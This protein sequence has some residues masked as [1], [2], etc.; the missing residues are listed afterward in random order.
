MSTWLVFGLSSPQSTYLPIKL[1]IY[2]FNY[3]FI[4]PPAYLPNKLSIP[5]TIYPL[6]N[7][8]FRVSKY[9]SIYL[10]NS[11]SNC[12][13]IH[14]HKRRRAEG[15]QEVESRPGR[16]VQHRPFNTDVILLS[17]AGQSSTRGCLTKPKIRRGR[18]HGKT[19]PLMGAAAGGRG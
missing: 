17:S 10:S 2:L 19:R 8:P 15:A 16:Q 5:Q 3:L 13:P 7:L 14:P 12:L 18:P 11:I 1:L 9:L 6:L 4:Y